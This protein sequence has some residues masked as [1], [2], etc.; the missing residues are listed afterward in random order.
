MTNLYRVWLLLLVPLLQKVPLIQGVEGS[1]S[2]SRS[3]TRLQQPFLWKGP[4]GGAAVVNPA[5]TAAVNQT[6]TANITFTAPLSQQQ[7]SSSLSD[8]NT[9]KE[10]AILKADIELLST[11]LAETV[12]RSNPKIHDLYEQ[13]RQDG[14]ARY[15]LFQSFYC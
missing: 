10:L 8:D 12:Q 2:S 14:L 9:N 15:V 11:I 3:W 1:S 7:S 5:A 13:F 4:R 6:T